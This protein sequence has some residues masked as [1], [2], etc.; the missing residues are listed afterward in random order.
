MEIQ[1]LEQRNSKYAYSSRSVGLNRKDDTHWKPINMQSKFNERE[2]LCGD[3]GPSSSRMLC[4]KWPIIY[5]KNG[6]RSCNEQENTEK[7]QRLGEFPMQHDQESRTMSLLGN[8]VQR[9]P[10]LLVFIEN[11]K[12]FYDPDSPSSYD[13]TTFLMKLLLLQVQEGPAAI[14]KCCE[15]HE[16]I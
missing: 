8:Q 13:N 1:N 4:K 6:K 2:Y 12:I 15:I 7:Q 5:L 16:T 3:E 10:E 9:L 11:L 14:L